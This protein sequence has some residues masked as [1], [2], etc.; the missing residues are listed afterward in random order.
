M[1]TILSIDPIRFPLT[2]IGRYTLEL[3]RQLQ[4]R[5]D[6]EA[7]RLFGGI[8]F[9]AE[10]PAPDSIGTPGLAGRIQP[11]KAFIARNDLALRAYQLLSHERRAMALRGYE[12]HVFHGPNF[13]LPR[14]GGPSIVSMHDLSVL[15]YPQFHPPERVRHMNR[16][17]ALSLNRANVLLTISYAVQKEIIEQ[18]GWPLERVAVT[19]LAASGAFHPMTSAE[20]RETL[21]HF[22]VDHGKY[23]LYV[24][25]MEPR[26]NVERLLIAYQ[27]LPSA[28]RKA[29]P[30]LLI[31]H[32]GWH[33]DAIM[34]R[35]EAAT[36]AGWARYHGFAD[37][38]DLPSLF[39]G[40]AVFLFPSLY[41]GFGL[42]VLEALA[43]GVPVVTSNR[44][45]LP[46]VAGETALLCEPEDPENISLLIERA[47]EDQSWRKTA[48]EQ[49]PQQAK[50]FSWRHCADLTVAAY[51][52]AQSLG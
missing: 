6:I 40:A 17:I 7:L 15:K 37:D 8:S 3:A 39:A 43:S 45:S 36:E 52:V 33:N 2:G 42:P 13:Y 31:G 21:S 22:G 49:G 41:E 20:T 1:K 44:S 19:P 34:R 23:C 46:E 50:K 27:T 24:G 4:A 25:T 29:Y 30:L 10:L 11:I 26:K 28:L 18:F 9:K 16:E 51:R 47:L 14:F 35:I 38:A 32:R 12:D 48:I 5:D